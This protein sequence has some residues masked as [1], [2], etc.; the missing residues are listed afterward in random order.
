MPSFFAVAQLLIL[1]QPQSDYPSMHKLQN[2]FSQSD[3]LSFHNMILYS[4]IH[5]NLEQ[6]KYVF[7]RECFDDNAQLTVCLQGKGNV[8]F[9]VTETEIM[10]KCESDK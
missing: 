5:Y 3:N 4:D 8:L 1:I 10:T 6:L 9:S 7:D 2:R